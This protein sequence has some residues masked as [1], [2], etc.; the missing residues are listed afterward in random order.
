M[1]DSSYIVVMAWMM[2]RLGLNGN[3][4]L[5]YALIYSYSQDAQGCYF[6]SLSHTAERLNISRRAAVD[7]LNRLLDKGYITKSTV[8][9]DGVTR[10]M[11]KAMVPADV[12]GGPRHQ[13][14][15]PKRAQSPKVQ[16]PTLD[17]VKEYCAERGNMV[18]AQRFFDFYEA[19][20]WCQGRG[21]P[22]RDWH[23]AVRTWERANNNYI[24]H[25]NNGQRPDK[26]SLLARR[27]EEITR[28]VA[29]LDA[30]YC[31]RRAVALETQRVPDATQP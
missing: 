19:N 30:G 3:E 12:D 21:K 5:A 4:L 14:R 9:I 25:I 26:E 16:K 15:H 28:E 8:D 23:A 7:V 20:G 24:Q 13:D 2:T 27:R 11:Y 1:N 17:E 6:G 18:D 22:I 10:C 29:T 31:A